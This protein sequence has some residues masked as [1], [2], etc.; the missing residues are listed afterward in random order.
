MDSENKPGLK[1]TVGSA[2]AALFGIQSN[3]NRERDFS[4]GSF[5]QYLVAGV[6]AIMVFI[7]LLLVVV[8]WVLA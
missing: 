2:I 3:K 4:K 1:Q 6:A 7:G 5:V 8:Q